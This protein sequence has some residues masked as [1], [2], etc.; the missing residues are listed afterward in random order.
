MSL[1]ALLAAVAPNLAK[2]A[3]R[4]AEQRNV[5]RIPIATPKVKHGTVLNRAAAP[6]TDTTPPERVSVFLGPGATFEGIADTLAPLYDAGAASGGPA[7]PTLDELARALVVYNKDLLPTADWRNHRVGM[8]LILPIEIDPAN[9]EWIV[10]AAKVKAL[11]KPPQFDEAWEPKLRT[12]PA[13]LA[14]P[15]GFKLDG[16]AA[17]VVAALSPLDATVVN[18]VGLSQ[19]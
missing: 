14:A 6:I 2:K 10:D 9:G 7:A 8:R 16:D 12:A 17:A 4:T 15:D 3:T 5:L 13:A 19:R 1:L 11:A 18:G